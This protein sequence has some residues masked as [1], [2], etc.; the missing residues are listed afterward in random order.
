MHP[1]FETHL[2]IVGEHV[3]D[4]QPLMPGIGQ[5]FLF[6]FEI[7]LDM[8][9]GAGIGSHFLAR[10]HGVRIIVFDALGGLG[11][12]NPLD[13]A[14]PGHPQLHG[15]GIMAIETGDWM[16]DMLDCLLIGQ[17]IHFFKTGNEISISQP[18][19]G[20]IHRT[21]AVQAGAGLGYGLPAGKHLVFQHVGMA[22]FFAKVFGKGVPGPHPLEMRN[23]FEFGLRRNRSWI[24]FAWF[25]GNCLTAA[26]AGP[27]HIDRS[28]VV[29]VLQ[30]KVFT[31]HGR[32]FGL[33]S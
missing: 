32:V 1:V 13:K 3:L 11:S 18:H 4:L 20:G 14:R 5:P 19:I 24:F 33:V 22:A 25:T 8:T 15:L 26:E 9:L 12:A 17:R 28:S 7:I 10:G 29:I 27:R 31:P 23:G 16:V 2:V 21:V 30:G 6:P